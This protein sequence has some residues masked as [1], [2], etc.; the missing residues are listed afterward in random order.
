MN[1]VIMETAVKYRH[2][3]T[4]N[5]QRPDTTCWKCGATTTVPC[6]GWDYPRLP[7][8]DQ[9][10]ALAREVGYGIGVHGSLQRDLDL[11]AA[12]WTA[13]AVSAQELIDHLCQGLV[14]N[15]QPARVAGINE[16][17]P[18][19]RLAV[20]IHLN[21]WFKMIDLSICPRVE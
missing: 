4:C 20:N 11:I 13:E 7:P 17:K 14:F 21:G 1:D 16:Q 19:G 5:S 3:H 8:V 9:I 6:E 10:R 18:L 2:C 15:G 12:P